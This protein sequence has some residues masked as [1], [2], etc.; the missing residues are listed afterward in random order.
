MR[1]DCPGLHAPQFDAPT[2]QPTHG[3]AITTIEQDASGRWFAL[4]YNH[5]FATP[6]RFCPFCGTALASISPP[7]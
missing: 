5:E 1:H 2:H 3:P 4:S 7:T 6:I